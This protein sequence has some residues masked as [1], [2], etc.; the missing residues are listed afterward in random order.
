MVNKQYNLFNILRL[1]VCYKRGLIDPV[2]VLLIFIISISRSDSVSYL[3]G[4][5]MLGCWWSRCQERENVIVLIGLTHR[6]FLPVSIQDLDIH[7][8]QSSSFLYFNH[9]GLFCYVIDIYCLCSI[10]YHDD[11]LRLI[12]Y[13]WISSVVDK[14]SPPFLCPAIQNRYHMMSSSSTDWAS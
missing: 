9:W 12:I 13:H 10:I 3:F 6:Y 11:L 5:F 14:F 7:W 2:F 1:L 4:F 8:L